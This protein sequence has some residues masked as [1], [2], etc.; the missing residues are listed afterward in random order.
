MREEEKSYRIEREK[1]SYGGEKVAGGFFG[2]IWQ[3]ALTHIIY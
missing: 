2:G 1:G 3:I